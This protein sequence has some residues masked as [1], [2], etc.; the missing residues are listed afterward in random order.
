MPY[1]LGSIICNILFS[2]IYKFASAQ[3]YD[4]DWVSVVSFLSATLL[5][6]VVWVLRHGV[7]DGPTIGLGI[8]FGVASGIAQIAYFR[9]LRHGRVSVS[10]TIVQMAMLIPVLVGVFVWAERPTWWQGLAVASAVGAVVLLGDVE[11]HLV[12]RPWAWAGWLAVS[13]VLSGA[14]QVSIKAQA[15]LQPVRSE[16][17]F[18]LVGYLVMALVTLPFLRGRR[19]RPREVGVGA[20]RGVVLLS[21]HFLMLNA[22]A[23]LPAYVMFPVYSTANVVSNAALALL[24]WGERLQARTLVGMCVALAAMVALNL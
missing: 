3:G 7:L 21:M 13:Y 11:L 9:T 17:P 15:G 6:G 24:I 23:V 22:A 20:A 10:W 16:V 1:L 8:A 5:L 4:V 2:Q 14:A 18:L 12:Q 19:P